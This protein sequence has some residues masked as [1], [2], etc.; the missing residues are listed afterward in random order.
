ME[1]KIL[2]RTLTVVE[3]NALRAAAGWP[4]FED[5]LVQQAMTN[6]LF[7]VC[8]QFH[9]TTIGMGRVIGDNAI[10]FHI[11]DVIVHPDFQRKGVGKLIMEALLNY[12]DQEGGKNTYIGLMSSKGR[13]DFYKGFGFEVRPGEKSGAGMTKIKL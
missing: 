6:T 11:M 2:P 7:S 12:V 13:E 4:V 1:F 8:V 10:Y 5:R 9:E 3:Y